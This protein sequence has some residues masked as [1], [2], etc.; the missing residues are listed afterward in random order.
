MN[1]RLLV[2]DGGQ[3][4]VGAGA[5]MSTGKAADWLG[6]GATD[7]YALMRFTGQQ[8]NGW[9]VYWHGQLGTTL[10]VEVSFWARHKNVHC[11]S[12]ALQP[13][14]GS[15]PDGLLYFSTTHTVRCCQPI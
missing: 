13:S 3:L 9:P 5:K 11:G 2:I 7:Y 6:S 10:Q 14:G 15:R 1:R 12:P 4:S 8:L